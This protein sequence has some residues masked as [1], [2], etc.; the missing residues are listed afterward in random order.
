ML[1]EFFHIKCIILVLRITIPFVYSLSCGCEFGLQYFKANLK[2]IIPTLR[3]F[4]KNMDI[5]L[6]NYI[7]IIILIRLTFP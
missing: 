3:T 7:T 4:L 1:L 5:V 2:H 6:H